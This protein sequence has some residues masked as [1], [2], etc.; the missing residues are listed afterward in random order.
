ME[1][2]TKIR[3]IEWLLKN[4]GRVLLLLLKATIDP[5]FLRNSMA[6]A[7]TQTVRPYRIH[8]L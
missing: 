6:Q 3:F 2:V 5:R 4:S 8:D 7:P 1:V